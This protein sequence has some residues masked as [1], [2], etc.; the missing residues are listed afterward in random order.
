MKLL[1]TGCAGFIGFHLTRRMLQD[2]H[3]VVGIDHMNAYYDPLLKFDR[4]TLLKEMS[5]EYDFQFVQ[6]DVED[7]AQLQ[8]LFDNNSF[9]TVCHLATQ[10]GARHSVE[11]PQQ[12]IS[13]N[14]QGFFNIIEICRKY[15]AIHLVYASSSSVYGAKATVPHNEKQATD[16]PTNLHAATLKSRE[17]MAHA[18]S[19]LYGIKT[20]GLRFFTVYGPWGRPDTTPSLFADAIIHHKSIQ[21]YNNGDVYRDFT[22]IDDVINGIALVIKDHPLIEQHEKANIYNIGHS[23]PIHLRNFVSTLEE[24]IG[25]KAL[26][27][28]S[29]MPSGDTLIT[30]ADVSHLQNDYGYIP[31]TSLKEGVQSFVKWYKEYNRSCSGQRLKNMHLHLFS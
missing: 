11:H 29:P 15:P 31:R 24:T 28:D 19:E 13:T 5:K 22:Y 2:G 25:E 8:S 7:T 30:W 23:S 20:T 21:L 9:D 18:Y 16:H 1:I 17:L 6:T 27:V 26:T 3:Q 14:V 12:Y 10:T 4:L